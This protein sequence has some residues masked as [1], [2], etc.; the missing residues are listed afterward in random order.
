MKQ[1]RGMSFV[2]SLFN[3]G[4]GLVIAIGAQIIIFPMFG[5]HVSL[6]D[7]LKLGCCFTVISIVRSFLIRRGFEA[8]RHRHESKMAEPMVSL[9]REE[10]A[11]LHLIRR[12]GA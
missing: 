9:T 7:N 8:W 2:E 11:L 3:Q 4:A 1:S 5:L 12:P 10:Q 6:L